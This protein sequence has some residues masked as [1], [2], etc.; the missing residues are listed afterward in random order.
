MHTSQ[1]I[2]TV[3]HILLPTPQKTRTDKVLFLKKPDMRHYHFHFGAHWSITH[4]LF[5]FF[6]YKHPS[7]LDHEGKMAILRVQVCH[8]PLCWFVANKT[9]SLHPSRCLNWSSNSNV[10]NLHSYKTIWGIH[11]EWEIS[12]IAVLFFIK[13]IF[14]KRF[15]PEQLRSPREAV[16][17]WKYTGNIQ[18]WEQNKA[19]IKNPYSWVQN[20]NTECRTISLN[21]TISGLIPS[22]QHGSWALQE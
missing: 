16:G 18:N 22:I 14:R 5:L 8:L 1:N 3:F 21:K 12:G 7:F 4:L 10:I 11:D 17:Q 13:D 19:L 20:C 2:R 9:L 15:H 6:P